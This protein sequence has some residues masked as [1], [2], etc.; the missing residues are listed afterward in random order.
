MRRRII[1]VIAL[2]IVCMISVM[3]VAT[4]LVLLDSYSA[5]EHR[6]VE[7]DVS[8]AVSAVRD[9]LEGLGRTARDYAPWDETY[10]YLGNRNPSFPAVN[11]PDDS[12]QNIRVDI[13]VLFDTADRVVFS[14]A[15][16]EPGGLS[17]RYLEE[18][19]AHLAAHTG[20][21]K[22][23]RALSPVTGLVLLPSGPLE[24][25]V[26]AV[27]DNSG[28]LPP[29][30]TLVMAR[31]LDADG[32]Q[33]IARRLQMSITLF[34]AGPRTP[35]DARAALSRMG[36]GVPV[37]VSSRSARLVSGYGLMSDLSGEPALMLRVDDDRDIFA[38]G[39]RTLWFISAWLAAAG[40]V[41]GAV[42]ILFLE[43][44]VLSRLLSLS[45]SVLRIGTSQDFSVRTTVRGKDQIAYLG[46][47]I[48]GMLESLERS[49]AALRASE[50]RNEA[51]LAAFPDVLFRVHR[52]GTLLDYRWPSY[53]PYPKL[54]AGLIGSNIRDVPALY[55]WVTPDIILRAR[56]AMEASATTGAAGVFEFSTRDEREERFFEARVV[57][58]GSG[59]AVALVHDI[60]ARKKQEQGE[61]KEVLL[62]EIHHRVKNNLQVISS[63]LDLQGRAARDPETTRLFRESRDRVR[64]MSLIHEKLYQAGDTGQVTFSDYVRDLT[65]QLCHSFACSAEAIHIDVQAG[66]MF[67][68]MDTAVPLGIVINELLTNALKHAF[69]DGRVG[70]ISVTLGRG[71]AGM[72]VLGVSDD[73]EGPPAGLDISAPTTLGLRIVNTLVAQ[74]GGTLE[75]STETGSAFMVRFP[76]P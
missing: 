13:V 34:P 65:A 60:T 42:M 37:V 30:G 19:K 73:G 22:N 69:P 62:K 1:I 29:R 20:L 8:R 72:V 40:L 26:H 38:N 63:M 41:L 32:I 67:L 55:P 58:S 3:M 68:D 64:S 61:L 36:R 28:R 23:A 57:A 9:D 7:K 27:T 17:D 15:V 66:D 16:K 11:F 75:L 12:L 39:I 4:R 2:T 76:A 56:A 6:Y 18:L 52:D 47:A 74:L 33:E 10:A 14:T 44:A 53:A 71:P 24:L 21:L 54:P 50:A 25:A 48:N 45:G 43:R 49:T 51:F 35:P 70:R 31:P 46:A 59:E 5:L